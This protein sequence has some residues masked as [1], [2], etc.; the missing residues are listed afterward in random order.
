QPNPHAKAGVPGAS[1]N[2]NLVLHDSPHPPL[3]KTALAVFVARL[4]SIALGTIT[5]YAVYAS[6]RLIAS[7]NVALLAAGLTAFNPMFLFITAS[8]NNDNLVMALNSVIIWQMLVMLRDGFNMR[9][10]LLL[11]ILI[12]LTSLSKLS[13]LV[14]IPVV[15]LAA[16]WL[17][18]RQRNWRGLIT[19]AA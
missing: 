5:V 4:F 16:L 15:I 3:E 1:D 17:V 11:A 13:G 18:S 8:V 19:L 14:L 7:E 6:A 10:S 12:A 9:R 2:K